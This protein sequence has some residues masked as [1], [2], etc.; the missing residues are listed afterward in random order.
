MACSALNL[1]VAKATFHEL[2]STGTVADYTALDA[3]LPYPV[4][5]KNHWV[6]VLNPSAGT[7]E[8]VWPL[9]EAAHQPRSQ[10]DVDDLIHRYTTP[11]RAAELDQRR[12][13]NHHVRAPD[14]S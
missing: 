8:E 10:T 13:R 11:S 9:V 5:A 12:L 7:T 4:Y 6:C 2:F 3:L 14:G 1:G